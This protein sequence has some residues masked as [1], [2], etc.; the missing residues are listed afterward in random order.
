MGPYLRSRTRTER[1]P[2]DTPSTVLALFELAQAAPV[3]RA[4]QV[5][6]L[7]DPVAEF[8]GWQRGVDVVHPPIMH[9]IIMTPGCQSPPRMTPW[10][11]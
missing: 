8:V 10:L 2:T 3:E 11:S 7:G 6:H 4:D 1:T 5:E 9:R